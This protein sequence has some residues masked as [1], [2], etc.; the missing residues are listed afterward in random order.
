MARRK[1]AVDILKEAASAGLKVGAGEEGLARLTLRLP[2][3]LWRAVKVY[4]AQNDTT[5]QRVVV[6]LLR[7]F[8]ERE[9]I[10]PE[11]LSGSRKPKGSRER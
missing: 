6:D 2:K 10:K 7:E 3:S 8:L 11:K 4:A 5:I 9:G 1:E